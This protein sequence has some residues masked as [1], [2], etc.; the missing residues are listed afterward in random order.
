MLSVIAPLRMTQSAMLLTCTCLTPFISSKF[1][2]I[3]LTTKIIRCVF[4]F[5]LQN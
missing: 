2:Y 3:V 4:Q 5:H 1:P